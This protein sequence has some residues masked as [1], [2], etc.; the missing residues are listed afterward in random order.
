MGKRVRAAGQEKQRAGCAVAVEG[1]GREVE[2]DD[3]LL[4]TLRLRAL[5][6]RQGHGAGAGSAAQQV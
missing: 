2:V 5:V 6:L 1:G 4:N 3:A